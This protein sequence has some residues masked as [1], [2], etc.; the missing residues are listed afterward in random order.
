[1]MLMMMGYLLIIV[2]DFFSI[3]VWSS[4]RRSAG[5][6]LL[7]HLHGIENFTAKA[8]FDLADS[9]AYEK[10]TSGSV[11][12]LINSYSLLKLRKDNLTTGY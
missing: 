1:M 2:T 7:L 4:F 11:I 9:G 12:N 6:E 3:G 8:I 5:Y 10:S